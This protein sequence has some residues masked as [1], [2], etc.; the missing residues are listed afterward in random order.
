MANQIVTSG[1]NTSV[2]KPVLCVGTLF[3][4][5]SQSRKNQ[6]SG[7]RTK[8]DSNYEVTET[9]VFNAL[10]RVVYDSDSMSFDKN[11]AKSCKQ[12][13]N[14][15]VPCQEATTLKDFNAKY[16]I[17]ESFKQIVTNVADNLLT[18]LD[19]QKDVE[20]VKQII[21]MIDTAITDVSGTKQVSD[22]VAFSVSTTEKAK[23]Y[24]LLN[25]V[26]EINLPC[27]LLSVLHFVL[28]ERDA[29]DN[30]RDQRTGQATYDLW[31]PAPK[32][33]PRGTERPF[34][35][36]IDTSKISIK[37]VDR[38]SSAKSDDKANT[39]QEQHIGKYKFTFTINLEGK[40]ENFSATT[41]DIFYEWFDEKA[42]DVVSEMRDEN[43]RDTFMVKIEDER[44]L[45]CQEIDNGIHQKLTANEKL[46]DSEEYLKW[47]TKKV[48]KRD[49][50]FIKSA[51]EM[52]LSNRVVRGSLGITHP[53][54]YESMIKKILEFRYGDFTY[55]LPNNS[56]LISLD[57]YLNS[58][59]R[60]AK[61]EEFITY[62][63][64][65]DIEKLF[66]GIGVY[67]LWDRSVTELSNC[68]DDVI[69]HYV[70]FLAELDLSEFDFSKDDRMLNL[71]NF[72]IG[73]H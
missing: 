2:Y 29:N 71:M 25:T 31:C 57:V 49:N 68:L 18:I 26:T 56:E 19:P 43:L 9:D 41:T 6:G 44:I 62:V 65:T 59:R 39:T 35:A 3:M 1:D 10:M 22:D 36:T 72:Y 15:Q 73:L 7:V 48:L 14:K 21:V 28:N 40:A 16:D 24:Q 34:T 17:Y 33:Q 42:S 66:G 46:N 20:L 70:F 60:N 38:K 50:T 30:L 23:K 45:N 5:L 54:Q 64:R 37:K 67:D 53:F 32:G 61:H 12:C 13:K 8:G 47:G 63:K 52:F 58:N 11:Q 4:L 55:E 27:F 51:L 69:I